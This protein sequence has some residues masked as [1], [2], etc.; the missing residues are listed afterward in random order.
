MRLVADKMN[1]QNDLFDAI[2]TIAE[3]VISSKKFDIT[4]ECKIVEIYTD[5][6]GNR[7]GIYKVKSQDAVYDAYAAKGDEYYTNEVVYVQIPNGDFNAQKFILGRKVDDGDTTSYNFELPL[8]N[9]LGLYNLTQNNTYAAREGF[10]AN[11]PWHGVPDTSKASNEIIPEVN[12]SAGLV[13]EANL[14]WSWEN[15][16]AENSD[17]SN[18]YATHLGIESNLTTLLHGYAPIS[19]HFGFK[20]IVNGSGTQND[21]LTREYFFTD[22]D[23]YGNPYAYTAGSAQQ[24]LIDVSDFLKFQSIKIYFYQD[25]DFKDQSGE[26]IPYGAPNYDQKYAELQ[27]TLKEIEENTAY[28]EEEKNTKKIEAVAA[29]NEALGTESAEQKNIIINTLNVYLGILADDKEEQLVLYTYDPIN[30]GGQDTNSE[31]YAA[32]RTLRLAWIHA[33]DGGVILVDT[34]EELAKYDAKVYWYK[35]D[36]TWNTEN[37]EYKESEPSHK[38]GGIYWRP[39]NG[40]DENDNLITN[41]LLKTVQPNLEVSRDRF[42]AVV[43]Y[44]KTYTTSNIFVFTNCVDVEA[45]AATLARNDKIILR[46][47][48]LKDGELVDDD[49][50]G[51]FYV[52]DENNN[53][54]ANDDNELYSNVRYYIE[55][56]IKV[57][58]EVDNTYD[59]YQRLSEYTDADGNKLEFSITWQWPRSYTMIY[60]SGELDASIKKECLLFNNCNSEQFERYQKTV[61]WFYIRPDYNMRY[62]DNDISASITINGV[63]CQIRK[64]LQ[65][66]RAEAFGSEYVPVISILSPRG[67]YYIKTNTDFQ[68]CCLVYDRKGQLLE[69][70]LRRSCKFTWKFLGKEKFLPKDERTH[71]DTEGFYG[72]VI[73]SKLE[74]PIPFVIEVTVR[75]AAAYDLTV[76]R[77]IMICN[78]SDYMQT[79]DII[80]PDRVEFKSDGQQPVWYTAAFEVQELVSENSTDVVPTG[81][82]EETATVTEEESD[83]TESKE[84]YKLIYPTWK[85]NNNK[86]LT[87]REQEV[88]YPTLTLSNGV[89]KDKENETEY[90]IILTKQYLT[91]STANPSIYGQQWTDE[92]LDEENFTYIYYEDSGIQVAQAIAFA[93]N[94]YPSS[95][96]NE[97]NGQSLSLD[98]E[99][100]AILAKMISAGTKD[101]RNRF[102]GVMMGDWHE[103]GDD[104]LDVPGLYG[105]KSGAQSFGFKTDGTGFIGP[106]GQGRIEFDG[107]NALISN[108]TRTCYINLNPRTISFSTNEVEVED[109]EDE[110]T[111][112][113]D[114]S[115]EAWDGIGSQGYSQYFLYCELPPQKNLFKNAEDDLWWMENSWATPYLKNFSISDGDGN[116]TG[117][118]YF[119]V[120]P[121]NGI[122]TT[123]GI[124]ARYGQI[125]IDTPWI[126]HNNGLTQKNN[127]G[128]IFLGNPEKNPS[129]GSLIPTPTFTTIKEDGTIVEIEEKASNFFS[130]SFS[131]AKNQIQTGIRADGYLYTEFATIGG[132]YINENEIYSTS[133]FRKTFEDKGYQKDIVNINSKYNFISFDNGHFIING[134]YKWMGLYGGDDYLENVAAPSK[135]DMLINF[136]DGTMGFKKNGGE[137]YTLINGK[138]GEA[139][140]SQGNIYFDGKNATIYCGCSVSENDSDGGEK[141][142][143]QTQGMIQLGA[144]CVKAVTAGTFDYTGT[145]AIGTID[146][147]KYTIIEDTATI[148]DYINGMSSDGSER[149][150]KS[151]AGTEGKLKETLNSKL[152]TLNV[153]I[154]KISDDII[155]TEETFS[156][157]NFIQF[158]YLSSK[159]STKAKINSDKLGAYLLMGQ[160]K[161]TK[162]TT[163]EDRVIFT[164]MKEVKDTISYKNE[165]PTNN[166]SSAFGLLANWDL[167]AFTVAVEKNLSV[168]GSILMQDKLVATQEWVTGDFKNEI[169]KKIVTVNNAASRVSNALASYK[170]KVKSIKITSDNVGTTGTGNMVNATIT[171]SGDEGVINTSEATIN[172]N[173]AESTYFQACAA[174]E[175]VIEKGGSADT[176]VAYVKNQKD[177]RIDGISASQTLSLNLEKKAVTTECGAEIDVSKV[178]NAGYNACIDDIG[179]G[180]KTS[181][182]ALTGYSNYG[183]GST[184]LYYLDGN[185]YKIAGTHQWRYDGNRK[186]YTY[187]TY[188]IPAKK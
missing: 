174:K 112:E 130:A 50:I 145:S 151:E 15:S 29:F 34:Q 59:G 78:N 79:H 48:T 117:T 110:Y 93:R 122:L 6:K 113:S 107:N 96:V 57:T 45:E 159:D 108:A 155:S 16:G 119:I 152:S 100:S 91:G 125:G 157:Q 97:W 42:K 24:I 138:T 20:I 75:G 163:S 101:S 51:N 54:L 63:T 121:N 26:K 46:C 140:F 149:V 10:W 136:T 131:N 187:T 150:P 2:Y 66:G 62:A 69:E 120:D 18:I 162:S 87:L 180:T 70:G 143:K 109:S 65:F 72:N 13:T 67:N 31:V 3:G 49:A 172:F 17:K 105:F 83:A 129:N 137:P 86:I 80:C 160:S 139:Y 82:D 175:V 168:K 176:I 126:I 141:A 132:W 103:K 41:E 133:A 33:V 23:M 181:I 7:T 144:I 30:Y 1:T 40:T 8:D 185:S 12:V 4:K 167:N 98:E 76:R 37:G 22:N 134:Q 68:L 88:T 186:T 142:S 43:H 11:C 106:S 55:P 165:D 61:Q 56:W 118:D 27:V 182:T 84:F 81:D 21:T 153:K 14:L 116:E 104:S 183:S 90:S 95:L 73:T 52:Y 178:Y 92:L 102:T 123:G 124:F 99:N 44:D 94:L 25:W 154:T 171:L 166:E 58:D 53:I 36:D 19:G 5:S 64:T 161:F 135:Y 158:Y 115:E 169:W 60:S 188:T 32:D 164:P 28:T 9:F 179:T 127:Y 85:I 170:N 128:R 111:I 35:Y 147:S 173:I 77:G 89:Q 71:E 39:L 184:T 148:S 146:N 156:T 177:A 38:L 47:A 114:I 74:Y